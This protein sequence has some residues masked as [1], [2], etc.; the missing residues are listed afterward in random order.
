MAQTE[1]PIYRFSEAPIWELQRSYYEEQGI[2]AWQ[3]EEVPEYITSNPIIAEAYAEMIFGF[4]QDRAGVGYASE[5]VT[6]VELGAGSGR[7]AFHVLNELCELAAF[8]G[9]AIPPFRYI[10]SDIAVKNIAYWQ[11]HP[12]LIPFVEKGILDFAKF[13]AVTDTELIL[14]QSGIA[15][16]PGDLQQPLLVIANYFFDSIPQELIYVEGSKIYECKVSLQFPEGTE[17]LS[18]SEILEKTTLGYHY[19]QETDSERE[20]YPYRDVIELYREKAEDSHILFP[21]IGLNCLERLGRLSQRGFLLITA[22]KGDHRLEN[23]EFAEPPKLIHHGSFSLTANYH[24]I[25]TFFEQKGALSLF[26]AHHHSNLNVGC[27]LMLQEPMGYAHTRLAYRR[28]VE[29]FGPDDFFSMKQWFD[30]QLDHMEL[31]QILALWRLSGYDSQWL[32]QSAKRISNLLPAG[33]EAEIEDIRSGIHSMWKTYYSVEDKHNLALDCGM[34]LYEMELFEDA[35]V[36]LERSLRHGEAD[37]EVLYPLSVCCYET[38]NEAAALEYARR[39]I[40]M[41]PEH[42]GALALQTLLM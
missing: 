41:E 11:R 20:T 23:W 7:L 2:K 24:A 13:D 42:E 12:C 4:L 39:T 14:I 27:I 35:L 21:A 38:G 37:S 10:M 31:R 9:I 32:L 5:P 1:Q 40:A 22:D 30:G 6:I 16:R 18:A 25:Q 33:N 8:A 36:F 17:G 3:N 28:F 19:R 34:L 26:T 15:I 29:R